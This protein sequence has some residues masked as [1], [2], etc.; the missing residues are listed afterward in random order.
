MPDTARPYGDRHIILSDFAGERLAQAYRER[1]ERHARE[2]DAYRREMMDLVAIADAQKKKIAAAWANWRFFEWLKLKLALRRFYR[3]PAPLR[4]DPAP[5][6]DEE[7][8][9]RVGQEGEERIVAAL[10]AVIPQDWLLVSGYKNAAG[11]TDLLIV[12]PHGLMAIEVKNYSGQISCVGN[13]WR[14]EKQTR[15]GLVTKRIQDKGGRP[16][17]H[18]VNAVADRLEQFL[19]KM[20]PGM[21][22][23]KIRRGVVFPHPN[24]VITQIQEP[25]VNLVCKP[26]YFTP[27]LFARLL[28]PRETPLDVRKVLALIRRDHA[29]PVSPA[30]VFGVVRARLCR[31]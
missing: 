20:A 29:T 3:Q 12:S 19:A 10:F 9:W 5:P 22:V 16:P 1:A 14:A 13:D 25:R 8:R 15:G 6:D 24:A 21:T 26:E 23:G 4:P 18:Q 28:P 27:E 30:R 2:L 7:I 11:E 17:N 31:V